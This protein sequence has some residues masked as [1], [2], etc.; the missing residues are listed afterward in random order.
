M[1]AAMLEM[2]NIS[3]QFPG[4]LA[5]DSATLRVK[6]GEVRA[7]VG[8]N[9]AGKS[10]LMKI[11]SGVHGAG[12][13]SGEMRL[14][15]QVLK[16]SGVADAER[17]G[18]AMVPQ[19]LN[20]I[21]ELTV[22]ENLMLNNMPGWAGVVN[23]QQLYSKAQAILDDIG[24]DVPLTAKI[25]ELG[26]AHKQ[27]V[28]IGKA[29]GNDVKV[30]ILDEPTATLSDK[31]SEILFQK[32]RELKQSGITCLYISHRLEEV[33]AL[34][35]SITVMRDGKIITTKPV[36][37]MDEQK[38]VSFM[39]GRD[40]EHYFPESSRIPG[41]VVL[42]VNHFD[43]YDPKLP[44]R[45]LVDNAS[46]ELRAG[47]IVGVYG[48]VG[49]GRTELALGL[50]GA[51]PAQTS[52]EV[53]IDGKPVTISNPPEAIEAGIGYLPEDRKR[54]GIV[55]VMSVSSNI[56]MSS[57]D[58]LSHLGIIDRRAEMEKNTQFVADLSIKTAS[59]ETAIRSLSG[60]NQQKC[61]LAR[62]IAVDTKVML[63][64]EPT[65]G[66]D[67]GAKTEVY[68]LLD[69]LAKSGKAI[70]LLSS[71]LPEVLGVSDRVLVMK[72]GRIVASLFP[73]ETNRR[74]I[75]EFATLGYSAMEGDK[76]DA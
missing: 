41:R 5:V 54:Q 68:A 42:T 25:K 16:L 8:E 72:Q 43:V 23:F 17:S 69:K 26:V 45:K 71:D 14:N 38:I 66:V 56:S 10:T 51:W 35:D 12:S 55:E 70:L 22:A 60:G 39:I 6:Q 75:L 2:E 57:I 61:V 63:L 21:D 29:L 48:L 52:G 67:I 32:I 44:D 19:E 30:L 27:M 33:L 18:I 47:E 49:A 31:E 74:Q 34:S 62:L 46:L 53:L 36:E 73:K 7:I 4:V 58:R 28:V 37:E 1:G 65:Q 64:D 3:I 20:L 76:K 13:Y 50:L 24:L 59:L 40:L 11:L 15:G 9:G